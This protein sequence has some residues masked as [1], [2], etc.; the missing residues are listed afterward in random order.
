MYMVLYNT[1]AFANAIKFGEPKPWTPEEVQMYLTRVR[2]EL[3]K[4]YHI[5]QKAR[6][7]WVGPSFP[8]LISQIANTHRRLKSNTTP[9]HRNP[10]RRSKSKI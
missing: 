1:A 3:D 4:G 5:Y 7:V 2:N 8:F 6:R 10:S 9:P